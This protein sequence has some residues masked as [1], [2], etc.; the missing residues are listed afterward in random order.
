MYLESGSGSLWALGIGGGSLLVTLSKWLHSLPVV[1]TP[2]SAYVYMSDLLAIGDKRPVGPTSWP[3][4][5][6]WSQIM[7]PMVVGEWE[8]QLT[9]HPD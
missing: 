7:T 2:D 6:G 5:P 1:G 9:S 8:N 4:I 3:N